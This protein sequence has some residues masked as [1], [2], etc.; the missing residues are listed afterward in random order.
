MNGLCHFNRVN[1]S[2]ARLF[3]YKING[4]S[5]YV[6]Y[7]DAFCPPSLF[8]GVFYAP[9]AAANRMCFLLVFRVIVLLFFRF[10]AL[11]ALYVAYRQATRRRRCDCGSYFRA[12]RVMCGGV[13]IHFAYVVRLFFDCFAVS[14]LCCTCF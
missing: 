2:T 10:D 13:I 12:F 6:A 4:V 8:R 14:S 1:V 7:L 11:R 3:M 5:I 9:R